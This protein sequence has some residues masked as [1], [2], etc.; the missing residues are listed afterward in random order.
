MPRDGPCCGPFANVGPLGRGTPV[1][2][3]RRQRYPRPRGN[4]S[5]GIPGAAP[6]EL[7]ELLAG[8]VLGPGNHHV[9][10]N[11]RDGRIIPLNPPEGRKGCLSPQIG[12]L[13]RGTA[14]RS[15][16]HAHGARPNPIVSPLRPISESSIEGSASGRLQCPGKTT[17]RFGCPDLTQRFPSGALAQDGELERARSPPTTGPAA[18]REARV[19]TN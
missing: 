9:H 8:P 12:P 6:H 10:S 17:L 16:R 2:G 14:I 1:R 15:V 7:L 11:R 5:A 3:P 4:P 18:D 19:V 13:S